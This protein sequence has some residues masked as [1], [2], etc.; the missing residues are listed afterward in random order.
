MCLQPVINSH[1]LFNIFLSSMSCSFFFRE[2]QAL[3]ATIF[4]IEF[5][6]IHYFL[7]LFLLTSNSELCCIFVLLITQAHFMTIIYLFTLPI[8]S[9]NIIFIIFTCSHSLID[10]IFDQAVAFKWY[11]FF[12]WQLHLFTLFANSSLFLL[13]LNISFA[14][15]LV[16]L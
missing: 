2:I 16:K 15:L 5:H 11:S 9:S 7:H 8:C 3:F 6:I 13:W 1:H 10:N 4:T 14:M 12:I